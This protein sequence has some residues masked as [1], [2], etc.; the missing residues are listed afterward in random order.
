[1]PIIKSGEEIQKVPRSATL[2]RF[3][4]DR[5]A[6]ATTNTTPIKRRILVDKVNSFSKH[7]TE[8]CAYHLAEAEL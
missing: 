2:F 3:R 1:M 6:A 4:M 5:T 8:H 7:W